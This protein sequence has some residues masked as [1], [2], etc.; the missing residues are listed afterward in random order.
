MIQMGSHGGDIYINMGNMLPLIFVDTETTHLDSS[1]GE[2]IEIAIII[3]HP[4][5]GSLV[6]SK[7][8]KPMRIED[9][10]PK[11]L[12]INGYNEEDWETALPFSHYAN[13]ICWLLRA[14]VIIGHR[15]DFDLGFIRA[16]LERAGVEEKITH[17]KIDTIQLAMEHLPLSKYSM[18]SIRK[19][20]GWSHKKSHT[21]L[22]DC[23]DCRKLYY[24]VVR[25]NI[26]QR[27]RWKTQL[28]YKKIILSLQKRKKRK[29]DDLRDTLR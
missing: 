17:R 27:W 6:W 14:G 21:A 13:Y 20:F 19:F 18:Y 3:D 16:G 23:K 9:A 10:D 12:E 25:S 7:K 2:I 11:A 1:I 26:F 24:T 5:R 22:K 28:Y 8:I 15:V 29:R 4:G